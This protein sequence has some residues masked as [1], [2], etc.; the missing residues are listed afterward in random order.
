MA[1]KK[2]ARKAAPKKVG[3]KITKDK[4]VFHLSPKEVAAAK[5]CMERSGSVNFKFKEVSV[6]KLP[7]VLDDGKLID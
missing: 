3:G 7:H 1:T 4:I 6:T 2:K 5:A